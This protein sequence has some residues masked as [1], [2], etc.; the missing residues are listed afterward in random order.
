MGSSIRAYLWRYCGMFHQI[1]T[2]DWVLTSACEA[3]KVKA[4]YALS[5]LLPVFCSLC[6]LT[7]WE[8]TLVFSTAT[9]LLVHP[10]WPRRR[11]RW[12]AAGVLPSPPAYSKQTEPELWT[13]YTSAS[14]R[15]VRRTRGR[16]SCGAVTV[17]VKHVSVW[18]GR[19]M[20]ERWRSRCAPNNL[21]NLL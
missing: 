6:K 3:F 15:R 4:G 19:V 11:R 7:T 21:L 14:R 8:L 20:E 16:S 13:V 5:A 10:S 18:G 12:A 9:P 2:L 17:T 1:P